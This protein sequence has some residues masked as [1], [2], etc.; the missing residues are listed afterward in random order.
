[1][2]AIDADTNIVARDRWFMCA[3]RVF[4]FVADL[5]RRYVEACRKVHLRQC[6]SLGS[7]K[8]VPRCVAP[9]LKR[10][11]LVRRSATEDGL[12]RTQ[13]RQFPPSGPRCISWI[14]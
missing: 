1:M 7:G 4:R 12:G 9:A 2:L 5:M 3:P 10:T 13:S 11:Q 6:E 14:T 8:I